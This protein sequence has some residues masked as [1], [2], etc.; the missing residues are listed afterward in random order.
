MPV[1][2]ELTI[3]LSLT[4]VVGF[5]IG[6]TIWGRAPVAGPSPSDRENSK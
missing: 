1:W 2:L 3:M 5:G 6:W 4:Y